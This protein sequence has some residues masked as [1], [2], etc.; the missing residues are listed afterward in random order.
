LTISQGLPDLLGKT[1]CGP[2]FSL[3][4]QDY[5]Y[6]VTPTVID[7][8]PKNNDSTSTPTMM[9]YNTTQ[10]FNFSTTTRNSLSNKQLF[11]RQPSR[12]NLFLSGKLS[13]N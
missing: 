1:L 12:K 3:R 7:A 2:E 4:V 10:A 9:V 13:K 5:G 6:T 11:G 8:T